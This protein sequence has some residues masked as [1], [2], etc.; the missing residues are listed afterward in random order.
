MSTKTY[1][2]DP[3]EHKD[4]L[5]HLSYYLLFLMPVLAQY[6]IFN[7]QLDFDVIA[8]FIIAFEIIHN[9]RYSRT[10]YSEHVLLYLSYTIFI[11]AYNIITENLYAS[12][13]QIIMR[14]WM[15]LTGCYYYL[16]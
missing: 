2:I 4:K 10:A 15:Y 9:R 13:F 7:N 14:D 16:I 11:V 6:S 3:A 12:E 1:I 8:V 5:P